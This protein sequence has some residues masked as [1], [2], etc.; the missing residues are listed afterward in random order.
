MKKFNDESFLL[1]AMILAIILVLLLWT[2]TVDNDKDKN[3][4]IVELTTS[5]GVAEVYSTETSKSEKDMSS[6]YVNLPKGETATMHAFCKGCGYEE[7]ITVEAPF[8]KVIVC[9]CTSINYRD[10]IGVIVVEDND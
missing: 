4:V 1:L 8:A 3:E 6:V 7:A 9:K 5:T 10:S 2:L